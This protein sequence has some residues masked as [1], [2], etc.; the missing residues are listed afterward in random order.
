[1]I[2]YHITS[3]DL[4]RR[5]DQHSP[6]WRADA[7]ART[8]R[9]IAAGQFDETSHAWSDVKEV[10]MRLQHEKCAYCER[11]LAGEDHGGTI[12]H[13]VEHFRPKSSVEVWPGSAGFN[14]GSDTA[15]PNGYF[16][17]AYHL[18]N[19][20]VACKKCNSPLKDNHF[21][22]R[23]VRVIDPALSPV[24]LNEREKPLLVN[25]VGDETDGDDPAGL[26]TFLGFNAVPVKK[27][28]AN[29]TRAIGIIEFFKLNDREELRKGRAKIIVAL[30]ICLQ[31]AGSR[32]VA[33]ALRTEAREA[34]ELYTSASAP[35]SSCAAAFERLFSTNR[36]SAIRLASEAR[37]YL[38]S[39]S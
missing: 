29:R 10:F 27:T 23:N 24:E 38:K 35:H 4:E 26:I 11:Q 31:T 5:V 20:A 15:D 6:K 7:E 28:G 18:E 39:V 30:S 9:F 13:D 14:F 17:L 19:Y 33:H 12:E 3:A 21:P 36:P 25:P 2:R 34:V 16:W 32:Q 37:L 22:V 1:M 8:R